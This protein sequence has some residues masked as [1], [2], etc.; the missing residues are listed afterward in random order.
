MVRTDEISNF[1][2]PGRDWV[3]PPRHQ[4]RQAIPAIRGYIYQF[5]RTAEAWINLADDHLLYL[6]VAEDFSEIARNPSGLDDVLHA[7]QVKETRESGSL[8]LNSSDVLEAI[9][10][11]FDLQE[12]N[13]GRTIVLTFLT[14]SPVGR[15]RKSPLPSGRPGLEAWQIAAASGDVTEIRDA[16]VLRFPSGPIHQF[17]TSSPDE[18]LRSRILS[19]LRF[20]CGEQDCTEIESRNRETLVRKRDEVRSSIDMARKAYDSILSEVIGTIVSSPTRKLDKLAF[21]EC[22]QSATSIGVPSQIVMDKFEDLTVEDANS[23]HR[24]DDDALKRLAR[25]LLDTGVPPGIQ[26]LFPDAKESSL[27]AWHSINGVDRFVVEPAKTGGRDAPRRLA[28]GALASSDDR[29]HLITAAPGSGK[30]F[31]LRQLADKLLAHSDLVPLFLPIGTLETWQQVLTIISDVCPSC[32]PAGLLRDPRVCVLLDGWSEFATGV[33]LAERARAIRVLSGARV[34]ASARQPDEG[35]SSFTLWTLEKLPPDAVQQAIKLARPDDLVSAPELLD[36]LRLPLLL[37]LFLLS[38]SDATRP[39]ELLRQFHEHL[40]KT[41]P[42]SL[43]YALSV[44]ASKTALASDNSYQRFLSETRH[45]AD[46][47]GI[48]DAGRLLEKLGTIVNRGGKIMPVHD[49]YWSWLVGCGLL[50]EDQV[51]TAACHINTSE[52]LTLALQSG[53]YAEV[54]TVSQVAELD[55]ILAAKIEA[56]RQSPAFHSVLSAAIERGLDDPRLSVRSRA[57]LAGLVSKRPEYLKRAL[58][59]FSEVSMARH[60]MP[61]WAEAVTPE[62]LWAN[63]GTLAEW[64]G[65]PGTA[66]ILEIIGRTGGTKWLPWIENLVVAQRVDPGETVATALAC[67]PSVPHW[68]YKHLDAL[69][70]SKPWLLRLAAERASNLELAQWLAQH[71]DDIVRD[72]DPGSGGWWHLNKLLVACGDDAVFQALLDRFLGMSSRSQE[73]LCYA[74]ADRGAPWI[75][76]FQKVAFASRKKTRIDYPFHKLS[77]V[78]AAEVDDATTRQWIADGYDNEGW[79]VLIGRYGNA[80]LPELVA[81]LPDSFSDQHYISA[82]ANMRYLRDAPATIIPEIMKRVR[83]IM[84]P[85]ATEHVLEALATANLPGMLAIVNWI[86]RQAGQMPAYHVHLSIRLYETW[87]QATSRDILVSTSHG[88]MPYPVWVTAFS[89]AKWEDHFTPQLLSKYP[90]M[91]TEIVLNQFGADDAKAEAVLRQV[92]GI[93]S[94]N[95]SLFQR[96]IGAPKLAALIPEVFIECLDTFPESDLI[97]LA[98]SEHVN[99]NMLLWRLSAARNPSH[100]PVH[101]ELIKWVL[102]EDINLHHCRYIASMLRSYSR[103]EVLQLLMETTTPSDDRSIWLVREVESVRKQRLLNEELRWIQ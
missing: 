22:F 13:P 17:L 71:Y 88:T 7:T 54:E 99:K 43:F 73:L 41:L 84:Q 96:M 2:K 66:S 75:G 48:S 31:S 80:I 101:V 69:A 44:A 50:I 86:V 51:A 63:R 85:M 8:T 82:L 4:A 68:A 33:H 78:F 16:L 39:G 74:V 19:A 100:K 26:N 14:T 18:W 1:G 45:R 64:I 93:R 70:K 11:L 35:D 40:A 3:L 37:S 38:E 32:E 24:L 57:G 30:T 92:K 59:I 27:A 47:S 87:H 52:S 76:K 29:R 34:L 55:I 65:S 23:A 36:L 83:G 58:S 49:L 98:H 97:K 95:A 56:S 28:V 9:Q 91:A 94:Y 77:E 10:H 62:D 79:R 90:E 102:S 72:G 21:I 15:E 46:A 89:A 6:E 5:H 20:V 67:S 12:S 53:Q 81:A 61:E 60:Y 42:E 103:H 25:T